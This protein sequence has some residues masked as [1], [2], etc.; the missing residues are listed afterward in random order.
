MTTSA[1]NSDAIVVLAK[2]F[3]AERLTGIS[4]ACESIEINPCIVHDSFDGNTPKVVVASLGSKERRVPVD[5]QRFLERFAPKASLLLICDEPLIRSNICLADGRINLVAWTSGISA[6]AGRIRVMLAQKKQSDASDCEI[7]TANWWA[8]CRFEL[9]VSPF[10]R[11]PQGRLLTQFSLEA[12]PSNQGCLELFPETN[13]WQLEWP[14]SKKTLWL[15]SSER[16]PRVS[17][18]A[19]IHGGKGRVS[20]RAVSGDIAIAV[21]SS[22]GQA[23]SNEVLREIGEQLTCGGPQ[24]FETMSLRSRDCI[25]AGVVVVEVR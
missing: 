22:V 23:L 11:A 24:V 18:M 19:A 17:D 3:I 15:L 20:L 25:S 9:A 7:A 5:C 6:I 2:G 8:A 10:Q 1:P 13:T 12:A 16:L 21:T 14:V 4:H